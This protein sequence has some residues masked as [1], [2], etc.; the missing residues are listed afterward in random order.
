MKH[1]FYD[2]DPEV[3]FNL[4]MRKL[5]NYLPRALEMSSKGRLSNT[6]NRRCSKWASRLG[7][8]VFGLNPELRVP[9]P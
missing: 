9:K 5:N 8:A 2:L 4:S 6:L 1:G 7:R 3:Q